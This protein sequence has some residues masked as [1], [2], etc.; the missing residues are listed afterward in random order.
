[1]GDYYDDDEGVYRVRYRE[2]N[3]DGSPVRY[4]EPR[5]SYLVRER[6]SRSRTR[7]R[8]RFRGPR[9]HSPSLVI[10]NGIYN[11]L[12]DEED[13]GHLHISVSPHRRAASRGR[14][15][16]LITREE[17]EFEQTMNELREL[18]L[19]AKKKKELEEA[20][21][22][23]KYESAQRDMDEF[24]DL[25]K[26]TKKR[27]EAETE[28]EIREMMELRQEAKKR[29]DAETEKERKEMVELR[30]EAK[31]RKQMQAEKEARELEELIAFKKEI[32]KKEEE[33]EAKEREALKE[34]KRQ[35]DEIKKKEAQKAEEERLRRELEFKRMKQAEMEAVAKEERE[36]EVKAALEQ[37]R[38][39]E[40]ERLAKEEK[41]REEADKEVERRMQKSLIDAGIPENHIAAILKG[42][43]V[44]Q[45]EIAIIDPHM[46]APA[47]R[48][49]RPTYTRV[50]RRHVSF[51]T[52]RTFSLDYDLDPTDSEY[53]LIKRW[54]PE[55]EQESLWKHT[56][57]VREKRRV[58]M[59]EE[60]RPHRHRHDPEFEWVRRS[61]SSR[62]SRTRSPGLL[63]YLA[64]AR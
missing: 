31:K 37:Y 8:E 51:E 41:E 3:R 59:L 43:K 48:D 33:K 46:S 10:N 36:K 11:D 29:K 28:R 7:S 1:M 45:N 53:I 5:T 16:P 52:L 20:D 64:G 18:R 4:V 2:R 49:S 62:R 38:I 61:G 22:K 56:R 54:V 25:K 60:R 50:A 47:H 24:H 57:Y 63:M 19:E 23:K 35:L 27:K 40:M 44:Q 12:S 9:G 32:K 6:S 55:E 30:D 42:E 58:L 34:A 39:K 17:L 26:E 21:E 15:G 14:S 13:E